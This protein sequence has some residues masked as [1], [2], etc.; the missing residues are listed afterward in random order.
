M[1]I[2]SYSYM[3]SKCSGIFSSAFADPLASI[4]QAI[5]ADLTTIA[6]QIAS[7]VETGIS[8]N[9]YIK[10]ENGDALQAAISELERCNCSILALSS[11]KV[12]KL[13]WFSNLSNAD[14]VALQ[15]ALNKIPGFD[16]LTEDGE[17]DVSKNTDNVRINVGLSDEAH[18]SSKDSEDPVFTRKKHLIE[19]L[20]ATPEATVEKLQS[21]LSVTD[22]TIYRD[23]EWLKENGYLEHIG[24]KKSGS[25]HVTKELE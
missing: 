15:K 20:K 7:D 10:D 2:G 3:Q 11:S 22:R 5:T 4:S 12:E 6:E 25:W 24:S 19:I 1:D 16:K 21:E 9:Y 13:C 8:Q 23:I 14:I 17:S 18:S